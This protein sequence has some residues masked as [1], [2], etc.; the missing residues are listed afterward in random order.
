MLC[1]K[2]NKNQAVF[3]LSRDTAEQGVKVG[4]CD[5]CAD[6]LGIFTA[7]NKVESLLHGYGLSMPASG[8]MLDPTMP[9]EFADSCRVCG[10][11]LGAFEREFRLGCDNCCHIF[12]SLL[13]NYASLLAA[14]PDA[15]RLKPLYPG[16]PP[17]RPRKSKVASLAARLEQLAIADHPEPG[18]EP[19][20]APA[21]AK[22]VARL[23][24]HNNLNADPADPWLQT[25]VHI[26]RNFP[27]FLFPARMG[28][29]HRAAVEK[30]V[31]DIL[32]QSGAAS[33]R[34]LHTWRLSP[35]QRLAL[36]RRH[37][38]KALAVDSI[39][40]LHKEPGRMILIN[41]EDHLCFVS[42]GQ[43][44]NPAQAVRAARADLTL[45]ERH[46][47]FA[48]S[49]RFGYLSAAPRNMGAAMRVSVFL[50]LPFSLC[51]DRL[52][53]FPPRAD[54]AGVRFEPLCGRGIERHGFFTVSSLAPF[55]A[56][57]EEIAA[58]VLG[59]AKHLVD[60]ETRARNELPP[61]EAARLRRLMNQVLDHGRRSFRLSYQDALR[62]TSFLSLGAALGAPGFH[63]FSLEQIIP[64]MSSP[65]IM[66]RDRRR[67]TVNDCERRR[68]DLFADLIEQWTNPL[69]RHPRKDCGQVSA[70]N[71]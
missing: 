5:A 13:F 48:F 22:L 52:Q 58:R 3:F 31:S 27:E 33:R 46:A 19:R 6:E 61:G 44:T 45:F 17:A 65:Y 42:H 21:Q 69:L 30:H 55:H 43:E 37:F 32:W 62:L 10:T 4:F 68:A 28:A 34:M 54:R 25:R 16:Q 39:L 9:I 29:Q 15:G 23:L 57:E 66:Y 8:P 35:L 51:L 60:E 47:E 59:F 14:S 1:R 20:V 50:H 40:V 64:A 2:C 67:Y 49:P 12:G 18:G 41:D 63:G 56:A 36:E 24:R 7:L 11:D 26:R 71:K 53:L 70:P 38:H